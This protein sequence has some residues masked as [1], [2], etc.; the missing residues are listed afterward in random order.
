MYAS[1]PPDTNLNGL[2]NS[3]VTLNPGGGLASATIWIPA[4]TDWSSGMSVEITIQTAAGNQY[5]R[6]IQLP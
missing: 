1:D 3:Q 5:P 4:G 6:T 2:T